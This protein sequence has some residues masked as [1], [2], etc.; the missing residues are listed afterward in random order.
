VGHAFTNLEFRFARSQCNLLLHHTRAQFADLGSKL[1]CSA[2]IGHVRWLNL[3]PL[4]VSSKAQHPL[5][6]S[7][8]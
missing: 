7:V 8:G 2:S 4:V 5:D 1:K 6:T 3:Q